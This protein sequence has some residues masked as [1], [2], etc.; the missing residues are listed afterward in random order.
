MICWF[1]DPK[2]EQCLYVS[3]RSEGRRRDREGGRSKT[4]LWREEAWTDAHM[5][6]G[7]SLSQCHA[8]HFMCIVTWEEQRE[9]AA[10]SLAEMRRKGWC[11]L[12]GTSSDERAVGSW[13]W[14]QSTASSGDS[15]GEGSSP[16]LSSVLTQAVL[17]SF[18]AH[19]SHGRSLAHMGDGKNGKRPESELTSGVFISVSLSICL[20]IYPSVSYPSICPSVQFREAERKSLAK[21]CAQ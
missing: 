20:L 17:C 6:W 19:L 10:E 15:T 2:E 1:A 21:P 3:P 16:Y 14:C 9:W 8:R 13:P 18:K 11:D 4:G 12:W 5:Y 7:P